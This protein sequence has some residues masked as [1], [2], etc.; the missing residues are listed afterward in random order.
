[1]L[2]DDERARLHRLYNPHL[3]DGT[4]LQPGQTMHIPLMLKD[5]APAGSHL[6]DTAMTVNINDTLQRIPSEFRHKIRHA[7]GYMGDSDPHVAE[8]GIANA[9]NLR[10]RMAMARGDF[11]G[12]GMGGMVTDA[13]K[14]DLTTAIEYLDGYVK[15]TRQR[16]GGGR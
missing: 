16:I 12:G 11:G 5:A 9:S 8:S 1:M 7:I 3:G 10:Q 15:V 4:V 14:S 6:K 13:E 2:T